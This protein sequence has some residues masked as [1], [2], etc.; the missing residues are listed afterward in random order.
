MV[1]II[2][3]LLLK[4]DD[5][6]TQLLKIIRVMYTAVL[7]ALY[8]SLQLSTVMPTMVS[9]VKQDVKPYTLTQSLP[10]YPVVVYP[11]VKK[12]KA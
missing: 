3:T 10:Q 1:P 4:H 7:L 2:L 5:L 11:C 9:C 12:S 6:T 8:R